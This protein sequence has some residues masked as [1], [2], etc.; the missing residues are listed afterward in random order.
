MGIVTKT[1][2]SGT[3]SLCMGDRVGKN[4]VRIEICGV[5]DELCAMLGMSKS[6]IKDKAARKVLEII[7]EDL[8]LMGQEVATEV[9]FIKRLKRRIGKSHVKLLEDHIEYL[10]GKKIN[11]IYCFCLPGE[12]FVSSTL[13]VSR[14]I[15]RRA[16]RLVFSLKKKNMLK[17]IYILIYLNR[18][19]DLLYLLARSYEKSHRKVK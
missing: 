8:F 3:T 9:R 5:L 4:H 16:E 18:L 13:D 15:T 2:D 14:T 1:G 12:N 11:Q 6:V 17:S 10:E 19:S 7:Q